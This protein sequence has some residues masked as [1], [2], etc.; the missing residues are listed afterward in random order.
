[1]EKAQANAMEL[2]ARLDA[3]DDVAL[4]RYPGLA[5]D[6]THENAAKF[7]MGWGCDDLIRD[8]R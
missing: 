7:M 2:A 4:V 3:S 5:S 8:R 1:M 6:P